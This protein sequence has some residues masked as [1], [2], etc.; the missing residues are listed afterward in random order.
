MREAVHAQSPGV[1]T[2]CE[3]KEPV[4]LCRELVARS[5]GIDGLGSAARTELAAR[6]LGED[7]RRPTRTD[8]G[9]PHATAWLHLKE[10]ERES[11]APPRRTST[12]QRLFRSS[13]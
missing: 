4:G 11:H 2:F 7:N 12:A 9:R 3:M 13:I 5:A 10:S 6:A 1:A 8:Q